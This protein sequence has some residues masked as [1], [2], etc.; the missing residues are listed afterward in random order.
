MI[1][2]LENFEI[3]E[4]M[5]IWVKTNITAHS[6]IPEKYWIDNYNVVKD[7]YMPNSTTFIYK[8]HNIIKAFISIMNNSFIGALFVL[9]GYQGQGIGRKLLEY[10]KSLYS[11]LELGVY[12]ENISAVNVY[13]HCGFVVKTEKPNE[14]SGHLEYTMFWTK[15]EQY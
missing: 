13:K 11:S 1:K 15:Q 6:F 9:R 2:Q 12:T 10:C 8:E 7:E 3:E 14:D 4:V 5:E